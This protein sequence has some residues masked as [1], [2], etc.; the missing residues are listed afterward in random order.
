MYGAIVCMITVHY[1]S[2]SACTETEAMDAHCSEYLIFEIAQLPFDWKSVGS[3]LFEAQ[4]VSDIDCE[5]QNRWK[6][7]GMLLSWLRH[8]KSE[9]T[10]RHLVEALEKENK[11]TAEKVT[12]LVMDGKRWEGGCGWRWLSDERSY[13]RVVKGGV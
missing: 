3:H 7:M 11:G 9:A 13:G 4:H 10:Y 12:R 8:K 1:S 6:T 5:E 2:P